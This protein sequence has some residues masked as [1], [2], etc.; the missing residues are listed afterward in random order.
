MHYFDKNRNFF[1]NDLDLGV[2][3]LDILIVL[4][5]DKY[6]G[7]GPTPNYPYRFRDIACRNQK[8]AYFGVIWTFY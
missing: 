7:G 4:F 1:I 6:F 5:D 2:C 3:N 8:V